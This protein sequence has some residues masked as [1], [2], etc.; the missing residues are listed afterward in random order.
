MEKKLLEVEGG[1]MAISSSNGIMAI[2]PKNKVSWVRKKLEDGCHECIDSLIETLP[3]FDGDNQKAED[4]VMLDTDP[5][6][7]RDPNQKFYESE[8]I[9]DTYQAQYLLPEVGV[10]AEKPK[11]SQFRRA[12]SNMNPKNW[13]VDDYS[14]YNTRDEAYNAARQAG[15]PEFMYNGERFN[16]K[17]VGTA[18]EQLRWSGITDERI[19]ERSFQEERLSRNLNPFSYEDMASRYWSAVVENETDPK[20]L[21]RENAPEELQK[22]AYMGSRTDAFNFYTGKPQKY[23]TF[24]I[25][26][27][28]P[29]RAGGEDEMYYSLN[30]FKDPKI[31]RQLAE[32]YDKD[33]NLINEYSKFRNFTEDEIQ[34]LKEK[35]LFRES[36]KQEGV[37]P[38]GVKPTSAI[39]NSLR[40]YLSDDPKSKKISP[41][42][43]STIKDFLT[44][45]KEPEIAKRLEK[46]NLNEKDYATLEEIKDYADV[47]SSYD[48][49]TKSMLYEDTGTWAGVMGNYHVGKGVDPDTG[50][51]YIS[52]HDVW[53]IA[54]VNFGKPFNIYDR[55]YYKDIKK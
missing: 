28:K 52:Y 35:Y 49:K 38:V 53:D 2:I 27:Y 10:S 36:V 16:T 47:M 50:E 31:A 46:G 18:Q 30:A 32:M 26:Q 22:R 6:K 51:P 8:T 15:L 55:I 1:E 24:S 43:I 11:L 54:P 7:R 19:H 42:E 37:L 21:E 12:L 5:P 23:D 3:S 44:M 29:T 33:I 40:D 25:S 41:G 20:K 48:V 13:F 34:D 17:M 45:M 14:G 39:V 9:P 4:G